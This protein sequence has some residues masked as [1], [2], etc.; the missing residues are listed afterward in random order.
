MCL[1]ILVSLRKT[2]KPATFLEKHVLC[3]GAGED[4]K[5]KVDAF[6]MRRDRLGIDGVQKIVIWVVVETLGYTD[7][8]TLYVRDVDA[9]NALCQADHLVG[10]EP[11]ADKLHGDHL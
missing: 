2:W 3:F 11:V 5:N 4:D 9:L 10:V 7:P 8:G 1:Q 6:E